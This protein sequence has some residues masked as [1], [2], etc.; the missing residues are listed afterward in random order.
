MQK[1]IILASTSPRRKA[2]LKQIGLK[3]DV[4][5]SDIDES[6]VFYK[7]PYDLVKKLSLLKAKSVAEL[8]KNS[9]IISADT[10]VV[11]KNRI[12]GKP[13]AKSDARKILKMLSNKM[14]TV[15]TGFTIVDSQTDKTISGFE[16]SKVWFRKISG[17][18][19]DK[20]VDSGEPLDKAGAYGIQEKG[21]AF[22]K[23]IEGDYFNVVGLPLAKV[24]IELRKLGVSIF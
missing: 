15:I 4:K 11:F 22:V 2:L 19:I 18:E 16:E 6:A 12:I 7:N 17:E 14:H 23:K 3:F 9:I 5:S 8:S 21:G 10:V 1:H 24:I 20:Y 13:K